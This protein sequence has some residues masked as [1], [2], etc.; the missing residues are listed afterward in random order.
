MSFNWVEIF[1]KAKAHVGEIREWAGVK[2][3]KRPDGSWRPLAKKDE[4]PREDSILGGTNYSE[5]K[6][7]PKAAINFLLRKK[8]GQ[9]KGAWNVSG[10]GDIDIIWGNDHLGLKHIRDKHLIELDDFS[11]EEE[12]CDKISEI[13]KEGDV[14]KPY[15]KG[16]KVN[17]YKD[18]YRVVI[19]KM[20]VYDKDDNFRDK[21]WV[22]TS[23]DHSRKLE[24][25][26]KSFD[27]THPGD[28]ALVTPEGYLDI[29]VSADVDKD[30]ILFSSISSFSKS[31]DIKSILQVQQF[32]EEFLE[33]SKRTPIGEKKVWCE[34]I[35]VK[36]LNG[37]QLMN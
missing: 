2:Y 28:S 11:S 16:R 3:K 32:C 9:V 23:Y 8:S 14:G 13:L 21:Y 18:N 17:I 1:E 25:K 22:L 26:K 27:H 20:V 33:K 4:Y 29:S 6:L 31:K 7:R 24:E 36:T 12:M 37:W 19:R 35:Y 5:F 10:I 30:K 15:D 34:R